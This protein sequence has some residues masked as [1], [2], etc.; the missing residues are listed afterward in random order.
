MLGL[1][2]CRSCA[3]TVWIK[4]PEE[5]K[6]VLRA[7]LRVLKLHWRTDLCLDRR[8]TNELTSS[9]KLHLHPLGDSPRAQSTKAVV[10]EDRDGTE[11]DSDDDQC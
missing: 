9:G 5:T 1:C 7:L 3:T 11:E 4:N 6:A 10:I 8:L 2:Q